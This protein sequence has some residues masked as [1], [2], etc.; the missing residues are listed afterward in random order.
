M[1]L[2]GCWG[3]RGT[4]GASIITSAKVDDIDLALP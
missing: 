3:S 4:V 1:V 2:T